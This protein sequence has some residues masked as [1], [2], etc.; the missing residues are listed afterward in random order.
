MRQKS[1][2][3]IVA[4]LTYIC[5]MS[6]SSVALQPEVGYV[7]P[8]WIVS[9]SMWNLNLA[10]TT[11]RNRNHIHDSHSTPAFFDKL[12]KPSI[13]LIIC[14]CNTHNN[15]HWR[16]PSVDD[17][18]KN[19]YYHYYILL[20]LSRIVSALILI[21]FGLFLQP[22]ANFKYRY[23]YYNPSCILQSGD[24]FLHYIAPFLNNWIFK[25][26]IK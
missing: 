7:V 22:K 20:L 10:G 5:S 1:W 13:A 19:F 3:E 12:D 23:L 9:F 17:Y 2:G 11:M 25:I 18:C 16:V 26:K 6:H 21:S 15:L 24:I 14:S 8:Q 4:C